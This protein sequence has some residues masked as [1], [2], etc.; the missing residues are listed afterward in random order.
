MKKQNEQKK[1]KIRKRRRTAPASVP[2]TSTQHNETIAYTNLMHFILFQWPCVHLPHTHEFSCYLRQLYLMKLEWKIEEVN[3]NR[4]TFVVGI[5][6]PIYSFGLAKR[7]SPAN[8]QWLSGSWISYLFCCV[9]F[10]L[11][12]LDCSLFIFNIIND[13]CNFSFHF[14]FT[15]HFDAMFH[16]DWIS[17]SVE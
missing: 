5:F 16:C 8:K 4:F 15:H 2:A 7:S 17:L 13:T 11:C 12:S 6:M 9:F 1:I 10:S 14:R 3:K